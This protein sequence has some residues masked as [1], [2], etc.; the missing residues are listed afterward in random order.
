MP[1][2]VLYQPEIPI[3]AKEV[4]EEAE[5]LQ[6]YS[7]KATSGTAT[8]GEFLKEQMAQSQSGED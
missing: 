5:A 6:D 2:L 3:K 1:D 7:R 8:L 4:A